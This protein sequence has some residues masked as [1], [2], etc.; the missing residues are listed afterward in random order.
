M[1]GDV[2]FSA[3]FLSM[4]TP[5]LGCFVGS[6]LPGAFVGRGRRPCRGLGFRRVFVKEGKGKS[7]LLRAFLPY[8]PQ[9]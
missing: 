2:I 3:K 8:V 5:R 6:S 1:A 4:Q 9:L 7:L